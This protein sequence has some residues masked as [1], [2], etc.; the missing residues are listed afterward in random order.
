MFPVEPIPNA[1]MVVLLTLVFAFPS[2]TN[3]YHTHIYIY[4]CWLRLAYAARIV[5]IHSGNNDLQTDGTVS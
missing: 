3:Y 5:T 4:K 1:S 2:V